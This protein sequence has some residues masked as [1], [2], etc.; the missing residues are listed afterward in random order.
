V[1]QLCTHVVRTCTLS[2]YTLCFQE[3][4]G[5]HYVMTNTLLA[6]IAAAAPQSHD[7]LQRCAT[8][9]PPA[10]QSHSEELLSLIAHATATA[11]TADTI[12]GNSSSANSS[13][14][15]SA[16]PAAT[17]AQ[18][19]QTPVSQTSSL[20][21]SVLQS[22]VPPSTTPSTRAAPSLGVFNSVRG[23]VPKQAYLRQFNVTP[24]GVTQFMHVAMGGTVSSADA[25]YP[26][27]VKVTGTM[28]WLELL[29]D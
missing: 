20:A 23:A 28:Q 13:S 18:A 24:S 16:Q 14:K 6:R 17:Q 2:V 15:G 19:A 10:V 11:T 3:D 1:L 27:T 22:A 12:G 21:G 7:A 26:Y 5:L 9:L 29:C 8:A 4:E 25:E